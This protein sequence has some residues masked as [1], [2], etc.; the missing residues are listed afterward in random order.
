MNVNRR[1]ALLGVMLVVLSMTM[2]TQYATTKVG[3]SYSLVHASNSDIRY[4]GWD[5]SSDDGQ[6]VL[7]VSS[8]NDTALKIELGDWMQNSLKNYTAAFGIVNEEG[9]VVNITHVN[10]TGTGTDYIDIWLHGDPDN[11]VSTDGGDTVKVVDN[12]V[13]QFTSSND[14]WVL[15]AGD[16]NIRTLDGA[17]ITTEW[18]VTQYVQYTL[19]NT[20]AVNGTDD[21]VWV[22]IS[23]DVPSGATLGDYTG[24][25]F[26][27]YEASTIT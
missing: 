21:Y 23:I 16:G 18:D 12:G 9:F 24:T 17:S 19:D 14:V 2:A 1:L 26:F 7:R 22:Q 11:D 3:Y 10:V 20:I 13:A 25:I 27:H 4:I 6:R 5:N 8:G 15:V